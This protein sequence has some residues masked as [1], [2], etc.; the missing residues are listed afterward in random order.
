MR[1]IRYYYSSMSKQVFLV[2]FSLCMLA[3]IIVFAEVQ[4]LNIDGYADQYNLFASMFLYAVIILGAIFFLIGFRFFHTEFTEEEVTNVNKI[5]N[6]R[7]TI[8]LSEVDHAVFTKKGINLYK[9]VNNG[10]KGDFVIKFRKFG[11]ASPVGVESFEKLLQYKEIP[12]TKEYDQFPGLH[13][14][15]IIMIGYIIL[16]L[17]LLVNSSQ[18]IYLAI[19]LPFKI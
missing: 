8:K 4:F 5:F 17:S 19:M 6:K 1:T 10:K 13:K 15:K 14:S 16:C 18:A 12:F 2:I 7:T 11:V 9:A 3:R